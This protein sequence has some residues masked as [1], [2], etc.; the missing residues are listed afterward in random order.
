MFLQI[1]LETISLCPLGKKAVRTHPG[2]EFI[3]NPIRGEGKPL[4]PFLHV[5]VRV[6]VFMFLWIGLC[7]LPV[8]R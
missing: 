4:Q 6:H 3:A 1:R 8:E 2:D 5:D 7:I